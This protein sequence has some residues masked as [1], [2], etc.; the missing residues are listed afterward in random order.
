M[1]ALAIRVGILGSQGKVGRAIC[2][3]V[4]GAADLELVAEVGRDGSLDTF[5]ESGAQ[6]V[7]D[8]TH[9]DLS[10]LLMPV[11][12]LP[13]ASWG[14][15]L[16][17]GIVSSVFDNIP[18]TKMA[19]DQ[20]S[21]D[22]ALLAYSVGLGGSMVWFGSSAGVAVSGLFPKARSVMK[23]LRHGWHVPV[24]FAVGYFA[25]CGLHGW[26]PCPRGRIGGVFTAPS[27]CPRLTVFE[28]FPAQ[29]SEI[30]G[31]SPVEGTIG[32][33]NYS[34]YFG[35]PRNGI[36]EADGSIPFSST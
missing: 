30:A 7:I 3:A 26:N 6:V 14:T 33:C 27:D 28:S 9:P 34:I 10:A 1:T 23:W 15:T 11:E 13:K 31:V 5:V 19:L 18:L 29:A 16:V 25:L 17:L 24:S 22:S 36:E 32:R 8:F 35:S 12:V 20:V 21:Y 2:A 4:E